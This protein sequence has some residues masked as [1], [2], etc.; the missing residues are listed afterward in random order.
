VAWKALSGL[1]GAAAA[2]AARKLLTF[3]WTKAVGHEPPENPEHPA[4]NWGE[5][6]AWVVLSGVAGSVA[7]VVVLRSAVSAWERA[8]GELPP[9]LEDAAES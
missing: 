1:S 8:V 3:V 6:I 4:V 9:G 5:A 2:L 7:R